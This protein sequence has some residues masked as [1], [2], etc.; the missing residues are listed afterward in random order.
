MLLDP[1]GLVSISSRGKESSLGGWPWGSR[2]ESARGSQR[3]GSLS[4][5]GVCCGAGLTACGASGLLEHGVNSHSIQ[6]PLHCS[7]GLHRGTEG[8]HMSLP[9]EG[10]AGLLQS[11][12]DHPV[13]LALGLLQEGCR[14]ATKSFCG[15]AL[16]PPSQSEYTNCSPFVLELL[17]IAPGPQKRPGQLQSSSAGS[18]ASF[19]AS[20]ACLC[21]ALCHP[22]AA[23]LLGSSQLYRAAH[24]CRA[25]GAGRKAVRVQPISTRFQSLQ[26]CSRTLQKPYS[27]GLWGATHTLPLETSEPAWLRGSTL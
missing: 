16:P 8:S 13:C 26:H 5:W 12:R 20:G 24:Q 25:Q 18:N 1:E 3:T 2:R 9:L 10:G 22:C 17:S 15:E 4:G 23:V 6:K 19:C 7:S 11:E 14:E 27:W 21:L